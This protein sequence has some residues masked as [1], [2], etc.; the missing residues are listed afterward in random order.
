M[1]PGL[2]RKIKRRPVIFRKPGPSLQIKRP[3]SSWETG[4][5]QVLNHRPDFKDQPVSI[6]PKFWTPYFSLSLS[7]ENFELII[8]PLFI[9]NLN[10]YSFFSTHTHTHTLLLLPLQMCRGRKMPKSFPYAFQE[11]VAGNTYA[12]GF[13]SLPNLLAS[14]LFV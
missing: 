13:E 14:S 2:E 4:L 8:F 7:Y 10:H 5:C 12:D 3:V 6:S 1:K 9:F 11:S